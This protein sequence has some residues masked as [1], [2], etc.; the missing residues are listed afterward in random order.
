[1]F[2]LKTPA[3]A[4]AIVAALA[5]TTGYCAF[6]AVPT[7]PPAAAPTLLYPAP[8]TPAPLENHLAEPADD[9]G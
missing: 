8:V 7:P 9:I 3:I 1:M 4:G 6:N 5:G 2:S